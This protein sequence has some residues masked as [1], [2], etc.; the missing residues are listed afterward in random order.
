VSFLDAL[1]EFRAWSAAPPRGDVGGDCL[2][3]EI[4]E[5]VDRRREPESRGDVG[6]PQLETAGVVTKPIPVRLR[7]RGRLEVD[8]RGSSSPI[9]AWR[10]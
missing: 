8:D 6:L 3:S 5:V 1:P 9:S 2:D 4:E 7:P 10:T